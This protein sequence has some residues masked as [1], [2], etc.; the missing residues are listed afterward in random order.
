MYK[1]SRRLGDGAPQIIY[2]YYVSVDAYLVAKSVL[3]LLCVQ[4]WQTS[5]NGMEELRG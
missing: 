1:Y 4:I 5:C 2:Y 3:H